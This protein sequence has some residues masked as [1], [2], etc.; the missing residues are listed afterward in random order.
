MILVAQ[1]PELHRR[2]PES[3]AARARLE[4]RI[5]LDIEVADST[6]K[7]VRGLS[8]NDFVLLD[9]GDPKPLTSFQEIDG[10]S[11][12]P[13]V[14]AILVLDA[15]NATFEDVGIMRQGIDAFLHQDG[16]RLP[17]PV[18]IALLTDTGIKLNQPSSNG[19]ELAR[20]FSKFE[21]PIPVL[22][23][24]QG[25]GG[26]IDRVQRSLH[27]LQVLSTYE[28]STPGRKLLLWMGPG[29]P[30]L[31]GPKT[32]TPSAANARR[33]YSW[34]V[35][36]TTQLRRAHI[37]L[38]SVA[39]L[40][41]AHNN[42]Q[43][44]F[45]YQAFLKGVITPAQADSP[46]LGVQVLATHSGGLVLNKSGDL[47]S[48]IRRC[49]ADGSSFYEV[50][51]DATPGDE[52]GVYRSIDVTVDRPGAT[53]RTNTAYY[54][55][56]TQ[57]TGGSLQTG[58]S[59]LSPVM[60]EP[61][62]RTQARLV[63]LDV[64]VLDNKGTPITGLSPNDFQLLDDGH[65]QEVIHLQEHTGA[66]GGQSSPVQSSAPGSSFTISN[67][68]PD[69]S[70][71]NVVAV[72][73]I[74][75]PKEDRGRLQEQLQAFAKEIPPG[76]PVALVS[77]TGDVKVL[78][79]F[80]D[81]QAGLTRA[82]QRSLGPADVGG[83]ANI[84]ERNEIQESIDIVYSDSLQH[85]ANVD[86]ERQAQRAQMT[87]DDF[88]SIA[89]WLNAYPG[90]KNVFWLSS[91]F[92]IE[93]QAFGVKSYND[94]HPAGG[95]TPGGQKVPMQ[96]KTDKELETARVAIYP[97]DVRGVAFWDIARETTADT[98]GNSLG[99]AKEGAP[100]SEVEDSLK[101]AQRSEMLEI[102]HATGGVARFNND[103]STS[104]LQAFRQGESY[105]TISYTPQDARWDGTYHWF[106]LALDKPG[107]QVVYRQ[108]YY[109]R[110]VQAEPPPTTDQFRAALEPHMPS[111]TSVL[112]T[113]NV[114][115]NP[116]SAEVQYA[117]DPSTVRF[118]QES[119]GKLLA[120]LDCA[121][122]EFNAKG[123]VLNKSLIRL[124]ERTGPNQPPQFPAT[125]LNAKQTI[126]LKP[127][128]TTLVVGVRDR[129]TGLFGTLQ[130]SIP[131][132]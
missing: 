71:W 125:A 132:H 109:A 119:D 7:A 77:M 63:V 113:V 58:A 52:V 126:A 24:T 42:G 8:Q 39:P 86:V 101:T 95:G 117:I 116:D 47:P 90:K 80:I 56:Q 45:L 68:P 59:A 31:A 65:P 78:S 46:N 129:A 23:S 94:L 53:T 55:G 50:T 13:P 1:D 72:D 100:N 131:V 62:L 27:A 70:I 28:A 34:I 51:F 2:T 26:A 104:L 82:L 36:T 128:A 93:G 61:T 127:G 37:T 15:M 6:G 111:A 87:L 30:L 22:E 130:V 12:P 110:D 40:N 38:Y 48:Q 41:L 118:T 49:L 84:V 88:A 114:L 57:N 91:G 64:T 67:K 21:T 4:R 120:D 96:D 10:R 33:Y 105:Y 123:K 17:L 60:R 75:T 79:S 121:I 32:S 83:P 74:N 124:S 98:G 14:E 66:P 44:T 18:S 5:T 103:L 20:D 85:K 25:T 97:L 35:D 92:P 11:V 108:G 81:G 29:W 19:L 76:T 112:F 54:A 3:E 99:I 16:G 73:L 9:K 115:P 122:L 89:K 43:V 107:V 102:A 69:G 106:K